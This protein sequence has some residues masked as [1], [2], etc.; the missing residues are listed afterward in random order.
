MEIAN[1]QHPENTKTPNSKL[2]NSNKEN[3][4]YHYIFKIILIGDQNIGKT[5]LITRYISKCFSENYICTIG[6]DF[7]MKSI[8]FDDQTI[9]L[10]IWDT[11]GMEKYRQITSSYYKGAQ[12]SIICFDLT[13]RSTFDSISK[14][15]SDFS[16]FSNPLFDKTVILVGNKSDLINERV[17]SFQEIQ[18]VC[19]MNNFVYYEA[20]A[21]TGENVDCIFQD[22]AQRLYVSYKNNMDNTIRNAIRIKK[23]NASQ[24]ADNFQFLIVEEEKKKKCC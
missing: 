16:K 3:I 7:M 18:N 11:A 17:V 20:S 4:N 2:K 5:S 1:S 10:Q 8:T 24:G 12:A 15:Y 22:L 13:N 6:V 21:K 23:S 19:N 14:W 9:K